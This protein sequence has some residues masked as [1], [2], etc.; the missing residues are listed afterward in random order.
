[1]DED[2]AKI[3]AGFGVVGLNCNCFVALSNSFRASAF[4]IQNYAKIDVL[5][6]LFPWV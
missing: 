6:E 5:H 4:I 2:H 1:M 3:I